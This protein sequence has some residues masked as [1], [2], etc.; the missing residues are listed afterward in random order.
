[1]S[2][3]RSQV[4]FS[5]TDALGV[6]FPEAKHLALQRRHRK[7][8]T[9]HQHRADRTRRFG[10]LPGQSRPYPSPKCRLRVHLEEMRRNSRVGT[11]IHFSTGALLTV[12]EDDCDGSNMRIYVS[13]GSIILAW[14]SILLP[15]YFIA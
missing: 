5:S 8:M 2:S 12:E 1:M 15:A 13:R 6:D 3:T 14:F 9:A 11:R 10:I 4:V 7:L